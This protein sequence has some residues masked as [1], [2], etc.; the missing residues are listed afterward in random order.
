[1][2][3]FGSCPG[4]RLGHSRIGHGEGRDRSGCAIENPEGTNSADTGG[5]VSPGLPK[6]DDWL[7]ESGEGKVVTSIDDIDRDECNWIHNINSCTPEELEETGMAPVSGSITVGEP[8]PAGEPEPETGVGGKSEP[9]FVDGEPGYIQTT[10]P[11]CVADQG[12]YLT[13][14]GQVGCTDVVVLDDGEQ[15]PSQ[16]KPPVVMPQLEPSAE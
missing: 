2:A 4:P 10:E 14:D 3:Y 9:L 13:S 8:Y 7:S 15:D 16:A 11:E 5:E 6:Y 1:M 12:V